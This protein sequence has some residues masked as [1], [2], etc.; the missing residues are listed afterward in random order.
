[1]NWIYV[2]WGEDSY[3]EFMQSAQD[4]IVGKCPSWDL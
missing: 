3:R 1:M 2:F 4:H